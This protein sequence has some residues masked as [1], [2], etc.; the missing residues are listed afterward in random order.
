MFSA[1]WCNSIAQGK[2][3]TS[4]SKVIGWSTISSSRVTITPHH[5]HRLGN[6][7]INHFSHFRGLIWRL[8]TDSLPEEC[9][10]LHM[11]SCV[12]VLLFLML[13][14]CYAKHRQ[15]HLGISVVSLTRIQISFMKVLPS[16]HFTNLRSAS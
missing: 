16:W 13:L 9:P 4:S 11:E 1:L 8:Y 14:F 6:F 2:E 3:N 5:T 15:W 10:L 12:V 7:T